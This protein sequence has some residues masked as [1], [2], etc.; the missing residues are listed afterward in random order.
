VAT[1]VRRSSVHIPLTMVPYFY[2]PRL[3]QL[4]K[5]KGLGPIFDPPQSLSINDYNVVAGI[6]GKILGISAEGMCDD[7]SESLEHLHVGRG[8]RPFE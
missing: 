4:R 6:A 8:P 5:I 1:S 2:P 3:E 7:D